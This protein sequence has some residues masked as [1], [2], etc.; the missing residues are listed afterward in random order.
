[1]GKN[2]IEKWDISS[3][4]CQN[5][6][7]TFDKVCEFLKHSFAVSPPPIQ[8]G[9]GAPCFYGE[10]Q[11]Y[12]RRHRRLANCIKTVLAWRL[13]APASQSARHHTKLLC[14]LNLVGWCQ[15][16]NHNH[17]VSYNL[18]WHHQKNKKLFCIR[19]REWVSF[20]IPTISCVIAK[21]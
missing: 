17:I 3:N 20:L 8:V 6:N 2:N 16:I 15:K 19:V 4:E 5:T 7:F 10:W 14:H 12:I 1:M 18:S 9:V 13:H 21:I 11:T